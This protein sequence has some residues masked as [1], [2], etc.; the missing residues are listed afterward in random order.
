MLYDGRDLKPTASVDGV[1]AGAVARHFGLDP[2]L[3]LGK[4]FPGAAAK[5]VDGLVA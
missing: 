5:A 1:I 3:A 4:L 2:A